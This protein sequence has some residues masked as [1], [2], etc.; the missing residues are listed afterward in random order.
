MTSLDRRAFLTVVGAMLVAGCS[1]TASGDG[2]VGPVQL[3]P[4]GSAEPVPAAITSVAVV[5]DSITAGSAPAID[6]A[7]RGAGVEDVRIEGATSRRIEVGNGKGDAPKSGVIAVYELLAEGVDPSVWVIEL[8]TND[9]GSYGSPEEYGALID[10][11]TTMLPPS[12]PMVWVNTY[13]EQYLDDT[14]VFNLVLE[15]RMTERGNAVVADWYSVASAPDQT[16]LRGDR[17]HPNENGQ[18]AL[19]LLILA[20]LAQL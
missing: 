2:G 8:G 16:V 20:A 15:Q 14:L 12:K 1:K 11:I 9:V 7:L 3:P 6:A 13:R 5:G 17:L 4:G 18:N 10:A 19:A